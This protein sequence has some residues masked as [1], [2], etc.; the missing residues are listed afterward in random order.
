MFA[1]AGGLKTPKVHL[2]LDIAFKRLTGSRKVVKIMNRFGHCISYHKIE[3]IKTEATFKSPKN[4]LLTSS[5][6]KLDP[7][8]GMG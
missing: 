4:N 1:A 5:G 6:M 2:M 8:C 3:E 7:Q